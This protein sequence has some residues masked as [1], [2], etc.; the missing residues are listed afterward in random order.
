MWTSP[1]APVSKTLMASGKSP[2]WGGSPVIASMFFTLSADAPKSSDCNPM[3]FLSRHERWATTSIP[4]SSCTILATATGGIRK[5]A[6]APSEMSMAWTPRSLR[7]FAAS[8]TPEMS[9][10]RGRSTSTVMAKPSRI[11][12]ANSVWGSTAAFSARSTSAW[13][14]CRALLLSGW[15]SRSASARALTWAGVVP[16]QPPMS[17]APARKLDPVLGEV[18]GIL[19]VANGAVD[20][21]GQTGV[22]V[23]G[24]APDFGDHLLDYL[25][26][27][28]GADGA[29]RADEDRTRI[30]RAPGGDLTRHP[31]R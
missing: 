14:A 30:L 6:R 1:A 3:M 22:G 15:K 29:V 12:F 10:P 16:Q 25:E 23:G 17:R 26:H 4:A 21:L 7:S 28:L 27:P 5:R 20:E 18:L 9:W 24:D 11:F 19:I 2:I 31:C 8:T 13:E